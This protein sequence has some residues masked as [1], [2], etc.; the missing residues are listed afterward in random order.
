MD[1]WSVWFK[2]F[3]VPGS[4]LIALRFFSLPMI[5]LVNVTG[6][7][8]SE[9]LNREPLNQWVVSKPNLSDFLLDLHRSLAHKDW[10]KSSIYLWVCLWFSRT[11]MYQDL[12]TSLPKKSFNSGYT[13]SGKNQGRKKRMSTE[14]SII[15]DISFFSDDFTN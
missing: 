13:K 1:I 10:R 8:T 4:G 2:R 9:P 14:K 7:S 15:R 11:L 12:G 5:S 6:K 3:R